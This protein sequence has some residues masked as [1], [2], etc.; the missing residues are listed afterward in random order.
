[1]GRDTTDWEGEY[2]RLRQLPQFE[3]IRSKMIE[4]VEEEQ[5]EAGDIYNSDYK[6]FCQGF[7]KVRKAFF[8]NVNPR[9][10]ERARSGDVDGMVDLLKE[11]QIVGKNGLED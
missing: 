3:E 1:M 2:A 8:S 6:A 7:E 4:V 11:M 5:P 9:T 10:L